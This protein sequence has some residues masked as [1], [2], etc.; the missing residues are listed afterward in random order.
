MRTILKTTLAFAIAGA[1]LA[2]LNACSDS[3]ST[4]LQSTSDLANATVVQSDTYHSVPGIDK[5]LKQ[6][7]SLNEIRSNLNGYLKPQS[8]AEQANLIEGSCGLTGPKDYT[9]AVGN[10]NYT[11]VYGSRT[12]SFSGSFNKSVKQLIAKNC[13][14]FDVDGE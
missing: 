12:Q 6:G 3:D 14:V 13:G 9:L 7:K 2:S 5:A 10:G 8:R 1:S 4:Y 11:Y